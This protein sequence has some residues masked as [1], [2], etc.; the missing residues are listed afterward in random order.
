[1]MHAD[2][3]VQYATCQV[4][5]RT[6]IKKNGTKNKRADIHGSGDPDRGNR[7][8]PIEGEVQRQLSFGPPQVPHKLAFGTIAV[9]IA[10]FVIALIYPTP[11][12]RL[13]S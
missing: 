12:H 3:N 5:V 7:K 10:C 13:G 8:R 11:M 2:R 6:P 1:M 4:G 9:V